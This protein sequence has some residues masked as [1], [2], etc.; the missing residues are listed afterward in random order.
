MEIEDLERERRRSST[1]TAL[2]MLAD[3]YTDKTRVKWSHKRS[4]RVTR[5]DDD[6]KGPIDIKLDILE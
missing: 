5:R 1:F 3:T 4:T 2:S 6:G